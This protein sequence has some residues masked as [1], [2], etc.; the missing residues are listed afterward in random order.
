MKL[1]EPTMFQKM[2]ES[3]KYAWSL[4]F[5][6]QPQQLRTFICCLIIGWP[7]IFAWQF[8]NFFSMEIGKSVLPEGAIFDQKL[9]LLAFYVG[10]SLG[11]IAAG[12]ISQFMHSRKK[13]LVMF[14]IGGIL[15]ASFY[16]L[17]GSSIIKDAMDLYTVYFF[18]GFAAGSW[19]LFAMMAA[20]Q[21]GTNIRATTAITLTNLVRGFTIPIIFIFQFL[22]ESLGITTAA[23]V[24][25]ITLYV[26]AF[27]ALRQLRETH[28]TDL[29]YMEKHA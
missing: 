7:L 24:I 14:Y 11:D 20:E 29:D 18:L 10:S 21:F 16:L 13:P 25:G 23:A 9:C 5:L 26:C 19:I 22:K 3:N 27:I 4:K 17:L 2:Q 8:L 28:A 1:L 15:V 12:A 6:M